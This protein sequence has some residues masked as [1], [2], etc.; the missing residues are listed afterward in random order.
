M[1]LVKISE[2]HIADVS[3]YSDIFGLMQRV[4][5]NQNIHNLKPKAVIYCLTHK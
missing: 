5:C 1:Q 4:F 2:I 3:V